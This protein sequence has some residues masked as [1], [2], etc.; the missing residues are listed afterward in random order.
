[1]ATYYTFVY[2]LYMRAGNGDSQPMN[3][4]AFVSLPLYLLNLSPILK[5]CHIRYN[6]LLNSVRY[7]QLRFLPPLFFSIKYIHYI[8]V[9]KGIEYDMANVKNGAYREMI[10]DRCLQNRR[11]YSTLEIMEKCNDA[12][13]RRGEMPITATNTIRNDILAIESRYGVVVEE[14]KD[15]RNI[16]RRYKDP[17]FS[18]YNSPLTENEIA[19][20]TQSISLL[21][22]FDGMPGFE[23][24]N[25]LNVHIQTVVNTEVKPIVAFDENHQLKGIEYFTPLFDYINNKQPITISYFSYNACKSFTSTIHPYF[26]KEYNQR[27]FLFARDDKFKTI[28]TFALDRITSIERASVKYV[29]N[30]D[31]D[32][33]SY[34]DKIIGVSFTPDLEPEKITIWVNKKQLPYTLSKPLHKSQQLKQENDDGSAIISINVIPNFELAQL[35]LSFGERIKVLAPERLKEE[36]KVRIERNFKNYL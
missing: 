22:R 27:W 16:R 7:S 24:V 15:G 8:C 18:I 3:P 30:T 26:L 25:E 14:I 11:G 6:K 1:M 20:L 31:I 33:S 28:S 21:K 29:P 13:E 5:S 12:L 4:S 9:N 32:F 34:F 17:N 19:Q 36:I 2:I 35:L 10:I 23:W